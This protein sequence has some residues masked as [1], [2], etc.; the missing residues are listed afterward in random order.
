[1]AKKQNQKAIFSLT[2]ELKGKTITIGDGCHFVK[3]EL[4]ILHDGEQ[5]EKILTRFYG[6]EVKYESVSVEPESAAED[7]GIGGS[8]SV[9]TTK[10]AGKSADKP[11]T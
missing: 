11:K 7:N 2:G 10:S 3:G 8:L 1:M 9:E 4:H 5:Y 6:C